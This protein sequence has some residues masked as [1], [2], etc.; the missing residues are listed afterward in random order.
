MYFATH[1]GSNF[2]ETFQINNQDFDHGDNHSFLISAKHGLGNTKGEVIIGDKDKKLVFKTKLKKSFLIPS[3]L[4]KIVDGDKFLLRLTYSAQ[5]IDE[6]F[7]TSQ[8]PES[9]IA[10]ISVN[11]ISNHL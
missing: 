10:Q 3:I 2:I 8:V 4:Y 6:T 5:E 7:R 1:N 11:C 9:I